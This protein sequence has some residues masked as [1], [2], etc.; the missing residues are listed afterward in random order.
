[1]KDL[2]RDGSSGQTTSRLKGPNTSCWR[3]GWRRKSTA[4]IRARWPARP[5][6]RHPALPIRVTPWFPACPGSVDHNSSESPARTSARPAGPARPHAWPR[7]C[8][9]S[10]PS[11]TMTRGPG[12]GAELAGVEGKAHTS[13]WPIT[14]APGG[15]GIRQDNHRIGASH[16]GKERNGVRSFIGHLEQGLPPVNEPVNLAALMP[17]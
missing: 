12:V 6:V 17:G 16:L 5:A 9:P 11:R 14:L 1:M 15:H 13:C 3:D 8:G 4:L 2:R 7:S 10:S